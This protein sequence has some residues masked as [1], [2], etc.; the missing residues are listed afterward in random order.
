MFC[1]CGVT[2]IV[3]K[4]QVRV[5]VIDMI[6][7]FVWFLFVGNST[8]GNVITCNARWQHYTNTGKLVTSE[9]EGEMDN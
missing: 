7:G 8:G 4:S 2:R 3:C 1:L 9:G 6:I 5:V